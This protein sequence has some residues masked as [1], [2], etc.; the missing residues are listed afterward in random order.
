MTPS[1]AQIADRVLAGHTIGRDDALALVEHPDPYELA[2]LG[3]RITERFQGT[4]VDMCAIVNARGGRCPE[5]CKF[6]AQ[7]AHAD[8]DAPEHSLKSADELL[9]AAE[10]AKR[11]G[12]SHFGIVTAGPDPGGDLETVCEAAQA[13]RDQ[14]GI[15]VHASAG[16]LTADA[17]SRLASAGVTEYNHNLETARAFFPSVVSTHTHQ[18]RVATVQAAQAAGMNVCCGCIVGLGETA[19]D[20]VHLALEIRELG[21]SSVPLNVL[22]PIPGTPLENQPPLPPLDI[23]RT[24]AMFRFVMPKT[25]LRLAGGREH[26]LRD[27]QCLSIVAGANAL[28]LGDYLTTR[29]RPAE[30][31]LQLIADLGLSH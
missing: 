15:E 16:F 2:M 5:D 12:A 25:R 27:L 13:I 20:R 21:P 31:D 29:G 3:R 10:R 14:V 19:E 28:C 8:A 30:E 22:H 11:A 1:V 24:I 9:E 17:A 18:D 26:N 6:C 23:V 4:H 7:S